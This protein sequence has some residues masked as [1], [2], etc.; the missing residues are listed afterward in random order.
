MHEEIHSCGNQ[1]IE[2]LSQLGEKT[3]HS[4][5]SVSHSCDLLFNAVVMQRQREN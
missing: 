2:V 4:V 3:S 1:M 5:S